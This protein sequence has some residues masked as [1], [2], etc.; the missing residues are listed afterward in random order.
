MAVRLAG[1]A[2]DYRAAAA[3]LGSDR[4]APLADAAGFAVK[5]E[6]LRA[7]IRAVG[8]DRRLSRF[9]SRR[10][11][12]K[13]RL[14]ARYREPAGPVAVVEMR[15]AGLWGLLEGGARPHSMTGRRTASGRYLR[16]RRPGRLHPG[17]PARRTLTVGAQR[18]AAAM[19]D[20]VARAW[21]DLLA[22]LLEV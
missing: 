13:V 8:G 10:S 3:A 20:L 18:G 14:S 11:R 7:G 19:P 12:G 4:V 5:R 16:A 21:G 9:G 22:E 2:V 6:L 15:P 1:L 17:A